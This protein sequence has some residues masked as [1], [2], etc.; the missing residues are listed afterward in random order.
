MLNEKNSGLDV[1]IYCCRVV[2][3][4]LA[5]IG[6]PVPSDG[7]RYPTS[8]ERMAARAHEIAAQV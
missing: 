5:E 2:D 6:L 3:R 1:M 8:W 4:V 7:R